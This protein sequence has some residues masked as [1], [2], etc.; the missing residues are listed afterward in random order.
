MEFGNISE[1]GTLIVAIIGVGIGLYQYYKSV[2]VKR[3]SFVLSLLNQMKDDDGINKVIYLFH[4]GEF[5]YS[6]EFHGSGEYENDTDRT[7]LLFSYI[8]YLKEKR[9]ITNKEF[10]F[11]EI[12]ITQAL[13]N[14]ALIDYLYNLYHFVCHAEGYDPL[15]EGKGKALYCY[16]IKFANKSK[17]LPNDFYDNNAYKTNALY[18]H[19]LNF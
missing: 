11:F 16:L 18:H 10:S 14:E 3:S 12:S 15:K 19:Y 7:L 4:Y 2:I 13:H 9:I 17:Y 1:I 6:R 5:K 8:C